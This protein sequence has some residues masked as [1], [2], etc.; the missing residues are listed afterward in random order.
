MLVTTVLSISTKMHHLIKLKFLKFFGVR[1]HFSRPPWRLT[2]L[3]LSKSVKVARLIARLK[4]NSF[5]DADGNNEIIV[6]FSITGTF[7]QAKNSRGT[8]CTRLAVCRIRFFTASVA[9]LNVEAGYCD[10]Q[11][12]L[13]GASLAWR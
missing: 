6:L 2:P 9:R 13:P 7:R 4:H 10:D 3:L 1:G 8:T 5:L 11:R 12:K